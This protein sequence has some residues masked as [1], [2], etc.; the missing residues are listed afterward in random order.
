[1]VAD[2]HTTL[3]LQKLLD[4]AVKTKLVPGIIVCAI[5][6]RGKIC[7]SSGRQTYAEHAP[8][9][10]EKSVFDIASV[11]KSIPT[12]LLAL[13]LIEQKKLNLSQKVYTILPM[14]Q[15]KWKHEVTVFHLLT[16]TVEWGLQLSRLKNKTPDEILT[17]ILTKDLV[18]RPGSTY[19]YT[20]STSVVLGLV[21]ETVS[22]KKLD[23]LAQDELFTPLKMTH[24][25]FDT[26]IFKKDSIVPTEVDQWRGREIRGE[27]H[28]ES[29]Y[30]LSKKY[31][32][33]SAGLFSTA[34][35][36]LQVLEMLLSGGVYKGKRIFQNSTV[37]QM[38]TNQSKG[39]LQRVGL[40]WEMNKEFMGSLHSQRTIGKTGFTGCCVFMDFDRGIGIVILSNHH[41]PKRSDARRKYLLRPHIIDTIL[42]SLV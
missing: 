10:T 31:V 18:K 41:Y 22:G 2:T 11:T 26:S 30:T 37:D 3:R 33:G 16:Q 38:I 1:M 39:I 25:S 27:I 6:Q 40:G 12:S 15:G 36:L 23:Q 24:T 20:N 14:F 5:S 9:I 7:I 42:A 21:V 34:P 13:K 29:A 17:A 8:V 35:D 4:H 32:V 19:S 28:D